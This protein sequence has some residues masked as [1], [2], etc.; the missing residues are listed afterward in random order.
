[1]QDVIIDEI[2]TERDERRREKGEQPL[3]AQGQPYLTRDLFSQTGNKIQITSP[4]TSLWPTRITR[5]PCGGRRRHA[6]LP[7]LA[8]RPTRSRT[9][10]RQ[11]Y[12]PRRLMAGLEAIKKG[13]EIQ[14]EVR[15]SKIVQHGAS[16]H[17]VARS[18][19]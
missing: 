5:A 8:S 6:R 3:A 11:R 9:R 7:R 2:E 4:R 1:M 12:M 15:H 16:A 18:G 14:G 17:G 19:S 13:T 10:R